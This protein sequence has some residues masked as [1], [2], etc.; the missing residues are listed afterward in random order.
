M[1]P[2]LHR[3]D[4]SL[5]SGSG[6]FY[7][8]AEGF[9]VLTD[10]LTSPSAPSRRPLVVTCHGAG[11]FARDWPNVRS[12]TQAIPSHINAFWRLGFDVVAGD[13]AGPY[14]F[15]ADQA[16]D[17]VDAMIE[18][19]ESIGLNTDVLWY[20]VASMG[21]QTGLNHIRERL[22]RDR[23]GGLV[24]VVPCTDSQDIYIP[25]INSRAAP[26]PRTSP[27]GLK[28]PM[29]ALF[30]PLGGW[31]SFE[32]TINATR[33]AESYADIADRMMFMYSGSDFV[34]VPE[35]VEDFALRS[36]AHKQ[37]YAEAPLASGHSTAYLDPMD[38]ANWLAATV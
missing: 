14:W 29:D 3:G 34:C 28:T 31:P 2:F 36:G 6:A 21:T 24:A 32:P 16:L 23:F 8:A 20:F 7:D 30:S 19:A 5:R 35:Q 18:W 15:G 10:R 1:R 26:M 33:F 27:F 12:P 11:G 4:Y 25:H 9:M 17:A 13:N 22:D 38:P 37:I